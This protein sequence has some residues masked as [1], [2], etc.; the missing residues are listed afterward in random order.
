M[1]TVSSHPH[2]EAAE[3]HRHR[4]DCSPKEDMGVTDMATTSGRE[5]SPIII[6]RPQAPHPHIRE[7]SMPR[8]LSRLASRPVSR[9][10]ALGIA[11]SAAFSALVLPRPAHAASMDVDGK[12]VE[13]VVSES[14][15]VIKH[16]EDAIST[17]RSGKSLAS[18]T[19]SEIRSEVR[20]AHSAL[21]RAVSALDAKRKEL[22]DTS[23][24]S[25][26]GLDALTAL[27]LGVLDHNQRMSG[28]IGAMSGT[29]SAQTAAV[30]DLRSRC[31]QVDADL[32]TLTSQR[33]SR[34]DAT[35]P[36]LEIPGYVKVMAGHA[37][38][39]SVD[40]ASYADATRA[41]IPGTPDTER[42]IGI[43]MTDDGVYQTS[44]GPLWRRAQNSSDREAEWAVTARWEYVSYS[45]VDGKWDGNRSGIDTGI[46]R[47]PFAGGDGDVSWYADARV[48]VVD[49][50]TGKAA[51][52][53]LNDWGGNPCGILLGL[54]HNGSGGESE[55]ERHFGGAERCSQVGFVG[56]I[57]WAPR[58]AE[59]GPV[60]I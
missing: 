30:S 60:S 13:Q 10:A 19:L 15:E 3:R 49:R 51:I 42:G 12:T 21:D 39:W 37:I 8:T 1:M 7:A 43:V 40:K 11:A 5:P 36:H 38:P 54:N 57:Y 53:A 41:C 2:A 14:S 22:A 48:L 56:E 20:D 17:A 26:K 58:D 45:M 6:A 32:A 16:A 29:I 33:A 44:P 52:C 18:S 47:G 59:V 34:W 24:S 28:T 31:E 50:E 46:G 25:F 55:V 23:S 9:R 4:K 27:S 35:A